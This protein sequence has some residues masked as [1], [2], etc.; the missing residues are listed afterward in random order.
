MSNPITRS[1]PASADIRIIPTSPPAGPDRI[2][3]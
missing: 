1:N 3:S 2:A